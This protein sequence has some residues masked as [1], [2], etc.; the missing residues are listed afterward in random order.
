MMQKNRKTFNKK[1][2]KLRK[3]DDLGLMAKFVNQLLHALN[4]AAALPLRGLLHPD[5]LQPRRQVDPQLLQI[6]RSLF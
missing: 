6:P 4:L 3:L 5:A 2:C 1:D